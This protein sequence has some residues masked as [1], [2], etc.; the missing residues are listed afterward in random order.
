M[1]L[2]CCVTFCVCV[3]V[4]VCLCKGGG[5]TDSFGISTR[6][7]QPGRMS[8]FSLRGTAC[9][10][11]SSPSHGLYSLL[12]LWPNCDI[13]HAVAPRATPVC[14]CQ[15]DLSSLTRVVST[16]TAR[17]ATAPFSIRLTSPGRRVFFSVD[18]QWLAPGAA[19]VQLAS[20]QGVVV[21]A[22]Q[23][24]SKKMHAACCFPIS[25]AAH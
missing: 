16:F 23:A 12:H 10:L 7:P 11:H 4:C 14:H 15:A 9:D 24:V 20:L 17:T 22:W 6:K 13:R 2:C 5:S 3:C 1:C 25:S 8:S 18:M 21:H 19:E